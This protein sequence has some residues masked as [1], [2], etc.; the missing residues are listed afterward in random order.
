MYKHER[1]FIPK[2]YSTFSPTVNRWR[3]LSPRPKRET[4]INNDDI[5]N[6]K[7]ALHTSC[8]IEKFITKV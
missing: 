3:L 2:S 7:I 4:I 8:T 5:I 6:L 1:P